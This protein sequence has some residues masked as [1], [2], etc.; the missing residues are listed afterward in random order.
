MPA[1]KEEVAAHKHDDLLKEIAALKKEVA[2]LQKK[3][4]AC[5]AKQAKGGG[6]DPRVEK[7]VEFLK[8]NES[9][10]KS[11]KIAKEDVEKAIL[12]LKSL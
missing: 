3:C 12:I 7:L 2:A 5:C 4:D 1:K 11:K 8:L 9:R 10:G 6:A